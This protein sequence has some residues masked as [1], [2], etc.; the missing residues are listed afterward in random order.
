MN[1][2]LSFRRLPRVYEWRKLRDKIV[3]VSEKEQLIEVIDFWSKMPITAN[4]IISWDAPESWPSPWAMILQN[5]YCHGSRAYLIEQTL[6]LSDETRWHPSRFEIQLVQDKTNTF[7][8]MVLII[9]EKYLINYDVPLLLENKD[10]D[11][12]ICELVS[13]KCYKFDGNEHRLV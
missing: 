9:D 10:Y 7:L 6:F 11:D 13:L 4:E 3:S 12:A 1:P 8:G 5:D 2:F